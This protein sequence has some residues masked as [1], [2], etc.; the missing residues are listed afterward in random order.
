MSIEFQI[1]K[2][3]DSSFKLK[4]RVKYKIQKINSQQI[5]D[6]SLTRKNSK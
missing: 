2:E 3:P 5:T 4:I 1:T 6:Q